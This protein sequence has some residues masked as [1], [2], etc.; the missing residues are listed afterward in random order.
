M[1][2]LCI[3]GAL[4]PDGTSGQNKTDDAVAPG[5]SYKY[6]WKVKEEFAPMEFD[7]KCLT[8]IYHS[9]VDAPKDIASGLIGVLLTCKKGK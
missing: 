9:H 1:T 4:Y 5:K 6:T 8:W 7:S 3:Q 2:L